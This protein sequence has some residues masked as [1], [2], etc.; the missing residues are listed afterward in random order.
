MRKTI[1]YP[2][3][4]LISAAATVLSIAGLS[5]TP[6][7]AKNVE[8]EAGSWTPVVASSGNMT[9]MKQYNAERAQAAKALKIARAQLKANGQGIASPALVPGPGVV[10]DYFG[11]WGNYANSQ[12]PEI[13]TSGGVIAG[14]GIRKFVDT[15]P[16]LTAAG[17][18]DLG[19][20]IPVGHPDTITYP[21]T[22]YYE[23]AVVQ[24]TE[25]MHADLS[26]STLRGYVQL[27]YG[28]SAAGTNTVAPDPVHYLGPLI[29][30][31]SGRPVRVKFTNLLPLTADPGYLFV[32]VDATIM[33]AGTGPLG[34]TEQYTSN[35]A[36]IHLHG[37]DTPWISDGTPHQWVAPNLQTTSYKQG[38]SVANVPDMP[39]PPGGSVTMYFTNGISARLMFY[40]DH[41]LGITRLNVYDGMAAGYLIS[42]GAETAMVSGGTIPGTTTTVAAGTIPATQIPLVIQDKTFVPD[43]TRPYTNVNGT[44]A[45]QLQAQDPTWDTAKWG[46]TGNLWYP[47]VYM[48]NQNPFSPAGVTAMGRWDY[49]PWFGA[50]GTINGPVANEYY[51]PG[52]LE[53]PQRP[54]TPDISITGEAFFDT[55]LLNG[56]AYPTLTV[57]PQAYRFRILSAGNDRFWNLSWFQAAPLTIGVTAS[58]SGYTSVPRDRKSVV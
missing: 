34:G 16:G 24:Y 1:A 36:T 49:G 50:I 54:G 6:A 39:V 45:S 11:V 28:T 58:G 12:L 18:N 44:F 29:A 7:Q 53:P 22:D 57:Q 43:N 38:A 14:T 32:P 47:H 27:N 55:P 23:I 21:G 20:Y 40:H 35:R 46:G 15:L 56:T 4:C 10:P 41:A 25:K 30:A 52:G 33:G 51:V 19:Q 48:P 3:L 5:A 13:N 42:D 26:P 17:A 37:G 8:P 2:L 31:S 9:P